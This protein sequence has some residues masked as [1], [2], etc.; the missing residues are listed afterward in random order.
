MRMQGLGGV[1]YTSFVTGLYQ[2]YFSRLPDPSGFAYWMA[3]LNRLGD[4]AAVEGDFASI[5]AGMQ[6]Q[7]NLDISTI[8]SAFMQFL[9]R[10]PTLAEVNQYMFALE[11]PPTTGMTP[12]QVVAAIKALAPVPVAVA[13]P[14][15]SQAV[16]VVQT[17]PAYV[18]PVAAV[19]VTAPVASAPAYVAPVV[20]S[21]SS[22]VANPYAG[23]SVTPSPVAARMSFVRPLLK[24]NA[25]ANP[26]RWAISSRRPRSVCICQRLNVSR[27]NPYDTRRF[28]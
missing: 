15:Q 10:A 4:T 16:P 14:I 27:C 19:P 11:S 7:L 3:E 12:A 17:A 26:P 22:S 18:A 23:S 25:C 8:N 6:A 28:P 2:K 1:D 13:S 20:Q 9:G 5:A 24:R 21:S